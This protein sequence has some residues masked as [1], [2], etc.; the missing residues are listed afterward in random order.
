MLVKMLSCKYTHVLN[1]DKSRHYLFDSLFYL[2]FY[3]SFLLQ[4]RQ[5]HK[6][7]LK[8][9]RFLKDNIYTQIK[10]IL[11]RS[12]THIVMDIKS[13]GSFYQ[14]QSLMQT[15]AYYITLLA[16]VLSITFW[17]FCCCCCHCCC[18]YS[19]MDSYFEQK[20]FTFIAYSFPHQ[21]LPKSSP[22]LPT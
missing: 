22:T 7:S 5:I 9:I 13:N 11:F 14:L 15:C 20:C 17:T 12:Q 8:C 19:L 2:S 16:L 4:N 3:Q 6:F 10:G 21:A 18:N 1:I